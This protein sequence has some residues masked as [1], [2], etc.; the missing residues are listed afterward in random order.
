MRTTTPTVWE[1]VH[2][3]T[4]RVDGGPRL[5]TPAW[6]AWLAAPT[7]RSFAFPVDNPTKG[8]IEGFMTVRKEPRQRGQLYWTAYWRVGGRLHKVYL[9]PAAAVTHARLRAISATWLAQL[10]AAAPEAIGS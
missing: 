3:G 2:T 6:F 9:G 10:L 4:A 8:Y 5:D 7:T 1:D